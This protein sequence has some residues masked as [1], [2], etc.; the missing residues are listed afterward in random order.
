VNLVNFADF[1]RGCISLKYSLPEREIS[2]KV[3]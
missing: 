3:Q 2:H 1:V